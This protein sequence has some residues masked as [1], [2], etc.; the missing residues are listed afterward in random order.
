MLANT[1]PS[2]VIIPPPCVHSEQ[3]Q[4]HFLLHN[5]AAKQLPGQLAG[6]LLHAA[7][8]GICSRL[9][10]LPR[11][12]GNSHGRPYSLSEYANPYH[13]AEDHQPGIPPPTSFRGSILLI[14]L[15]AYLMT[16]ATSTR[17]TRHTTIAHREGQLYQSPLH[18]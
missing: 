3:P 1:C 8:E 11:E 13:M 4:T 2:Q 17:A 9:P 15:T 12:S 5:A 7:L 14:V 18:P 16:H 6:N 10:T